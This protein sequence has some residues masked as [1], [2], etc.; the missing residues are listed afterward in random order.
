MEESTE[1]Q[2]QLIEIELGDESAVYTER[3]TGRWVL[4]PEYGLW[5]PGPELL[6]AEN[7]SLSRA[8]ALTSDGA[9]VVYE[10]S[11]R[12]PGGRIIRYDSPEAL[13]AKGDD[14]SIIAHV[15]AEWS[16]V[17]PRFTTRVLAGTEQCTAVMTTDEDAAPVNGAVPLYRQGGPKDG[18]LMG[19]CTVL[20]VSTDDPPE[21]W[22]GFHGVLPHPT[23]T[24]PA[25]GCEGCHAVIEIG[26]YEDDEYEDD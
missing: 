5:Y 21:A 24:P 2:D 8:V 10:S 3:F 15:A 12:R 25:P 1:E 6:N 14:R 16:G 19:Y 26:P 7:V 17:P 18:G 11:R 23:S 9:V 22:I 20:H 4:P 13:G